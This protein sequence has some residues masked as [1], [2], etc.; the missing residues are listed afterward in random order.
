MVKFL[1]IQ[2]WFLTWVRSNQGDLVRQLQEL[3][4][5][6]PP[7]SMI[8]DVGVYICVHV[9]VLNLMKKAEVFFHLQRFR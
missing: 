7:S 5:F 9:S 8:R 1:A 6:V 2:Q 3:V 4:G